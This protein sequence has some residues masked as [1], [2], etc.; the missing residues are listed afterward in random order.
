V[1]VHD[2]DLGYCQSRLQTGMQGA[3]GK[4]WGTVARVHTLAR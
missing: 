4:P 2:S 1:G 3:F